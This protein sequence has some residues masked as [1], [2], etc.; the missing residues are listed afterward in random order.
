VTTSY[1]PSL[2]TDKDVVRFLIQDTGAD[3]EWFAQDEEINYMISKWKPL[4]GTLEFVAAAIADSLAA[5][6]AREVSYSAD[7]VS[8]NLGAVAQ[9]FRELAASLREQ[10]KSSLVGGFPDVGGVSPYEGTHPEIKPFAFG[11]GMHDDKSAGRQDYGSQD[12]PEYYPEENP[13]V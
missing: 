1:D 11:T 8:I 13:G 4:Y 5:R 7:G 10:H 12:F 9:Q 6:Y 3:S 2:A